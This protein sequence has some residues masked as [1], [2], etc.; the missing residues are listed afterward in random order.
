M[1]SQNENVRLWVEKTSYKRGYK[2]AWHRNSFA[3]LIYPS[4]GVMNLKTHGGVW[5]VPQYRAVWLPSG[6]EHCVET[7]TGLRM[8]SVYCRGK[9]LKALPGKASL[10]SVSNLL[11]ELILWLERRRRE[12]GYKNTVDS[13]NGL[14][15]D[16]MARTDTPPLYIPQPT[17]TRLKRIYKA[18]H[19]NPAESTTLQEWAQELAISSRGL[20][21][22]FDSNV[23]LSFT[24]FREQIRLQASFEALAAGASVSQVAY[25]LGFTSSSSFIKA[26]RLATGVTPGKFFDNEIIF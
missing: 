21:R 20:A 12:A 16:L 1:N 22:L 5:I 2:S 26:F 4:Q 6:E 24:K 25:E 13:V 17:D 18:L 7:R 23:G 9:L 15:I 3:Q 19:H 10:I 14:F 11:R 8:H